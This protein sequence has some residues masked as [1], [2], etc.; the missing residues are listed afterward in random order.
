MKNYGNKIWEEIFSKQM[1]GKYPPEYVIRWYFWAKSY[2]DQTPIR[3]LDLGCGMGN[4]SWFLCKEGAKVTA[5]D[6]SLSALANVNNLAKNFN[7]DSDIKTIHGDITQPL[8]FIEGEYDLLLDNAA[9][10]SNDEKKINNALKDYQNFMNKN[11][12]FLMFFGA[13]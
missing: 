5:I 1:W 8:K 10:Y 2:I 11:S 7:V 12:L 6:G 13:L 3:A 9:L 4:C